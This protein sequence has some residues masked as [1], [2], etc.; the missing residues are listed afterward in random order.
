MWPAGLPLSIEKSLIVVFFETEGIISRASSE[1]AVGLLGAPSARSWQQLAM[2]LFPVSTWARHMG[3]AAWAR[4]RAKKWLQCV[5]AGRTSVGESPRPGMTFQNYW[6][7][8]RRETSCCDSWKSSFNS[9]RNCW[10]SGH[11]NCWRSGHQPWDLAH[12]IWLKKL[13]TRRVC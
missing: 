7:R 10:W 1:S 8:P 3:R 12:K 11:I 5:K 13:Q 6:R 2:R 4:C 9:P